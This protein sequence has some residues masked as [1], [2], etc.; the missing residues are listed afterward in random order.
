MAQ[1]GSI[2]KK[3]EVGR[4]GHGSLRAHPQP[5]P[6]TGQSLSQVRTLESGWSL[7]GRSPTV[8]QDA[9]LPAMGTP[10][11][12]R[13][14]PQ[15]GHVPQGQASLSGSTKGPSS[16]EL[17]LHLRQGGA[18]AGGGGEMRHLAP[19]WVCQGRE[20]TGSPTPSRAQVSPLPAQHFLLP[21]S[22]TFCKGLGEAK[23]AGKAL[24]SSQQGLPGIPCVCA[25]G[26][27]AQG[28][29]AEDRSIPCTLRPPK[30]RSRAALLGQTQVRAIR[31]GGTHLPVGG[32]KET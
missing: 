7:P 20:G 6:P 24:S 18:G 16:I 10:A 4:S 9:Y 8:L 5:P 11:L 26:S 29:W 17:H 13:G 2:P 22:K 31:R 12:G 23:D 3:P 27:Q 15:S 28:G 19:W 25:V 1:S 14:L 21:L 30:A 32:L